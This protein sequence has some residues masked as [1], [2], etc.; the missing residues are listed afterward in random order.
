[1][2]RKYSLVFALL[3]TLLIANAV[4]LF[5][6][7]SSKD[8]TEKV[9][10][11]RVIDGDTFKTLD[12]KTVRLLNI[13]A[14]E[15]GMPNAGDSKDFVSKFE[16][17]TTELEITGYDKYDRLLARVYSPDYINLKLVEEGLASKFLVDESELSLFSKA[18]DNA[19][20]NSLGIWEHSRFYGCFSSKVFK[21]EEIVILQNKCNTID[22]S[23]WYIK[24]ESRKTYYFN[25]I[26][27]GKINLHSTLGKD[28]ATDIF[29]N[30]QADIWNNDRDTFYLFDKEG[31]I[32]HHESYGY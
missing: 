9:I 8:A 20:A 21:K 22:V 3:I 32:V 10:I 13:N 29:W 27:L 6:S 18:E 28:N 16:N 26:S 30:S 31:R 2:N 23:G 25:G 15:K 14:P 1:M 19:I 5:N 24:D 11:G 17:K 12:G 4:Y 7:G